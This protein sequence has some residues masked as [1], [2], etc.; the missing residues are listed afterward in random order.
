MNRAPAAVAAVF[1]AS[2]TIACSQPSE[3]AACSARLVVSVNEGAALTFSWSPGDCGAVDLSVSEAG[4]A[5]KWLVQSASA[6]NALLPPVAYGQV[7]AG[8]F[9]ATPPETLLPGITYH[10]GMSR[11]RAD[12]SEFLAGESDFVVSRSQQCQAP[13][14]LPLRAES[15]SAAGA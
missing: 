12:G 4:S 9:S 1:A 3:P 6:S 8:A 10:V 15:K 7:P 14:G 5:I 11:R 13:L 2:V